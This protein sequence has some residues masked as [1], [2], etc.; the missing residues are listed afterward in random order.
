MSDPSGGAGAPGG[1]DGLLEEVREFVRE[2]DWSQ[3]HSPKN[4]SMALS[5]E[6][7]ELV[8]IFQWLRPEQA[9]DIAAD[10]A[11]Q[12]HVGEEIAD[13]LVYL[14]QIADRCGI[15]VEAAVERKIGLNALKYPVPT[16]PQPA[17]TDSGVADDPSPEPRAD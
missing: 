8:E 13:V 3:Y 5:V 17:P 9:A 16:S 15:D 12:Q 6:A 7:S 4:L 1:L 10:A 14:L 11:R 2:R